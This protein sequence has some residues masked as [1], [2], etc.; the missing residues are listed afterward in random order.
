M[1]D[2]IS[3]LLMF[4]ASVVQ[5]LGVTVF[6]PIV[7]TIVGV[8]MGLA[9][10]K[11]LR[12]GLAF[13]IGLVGIFAV[14]GIFVGALGPIS[15]ALVETIGFKFKSIDMGWIYW[16]GQGYI[17]WG[18]AI[19]FAVGVLFNIFLLFLGYKR[20][21][22]DSIDVYDIT[23]VFGTM[24]VSAYVVWLATGNL[25]LA[26]LTE[27]IAIYVSL[28][29][30][31][32]TAPLT[33]DPESFNFPGITFA[34][35]LSENAPKALFI[36]K[37][38]VSKLPFIGKVKAD[39]ETVKN[40]Y[41][42]IGDPVIIGFVIGLA[43]GLI[44]TATG[45]VTIYQALN[46]AISSAAAMLLMPRMIGVLMEG[47]TPIGDAVRAWTEKHLPGRRLNI[48][49]DWALASGNVTMLAV[50]SILIPIILGL[51]IILPGISAMP[52]SDLALPMIMALIFVGATKGHLLR[53]IVGTTI[54]VIPSLYLMSL[55]APLCT[56]SA[57]SLNMVVPAGFLATS[58]AASF[59]PH[60]VIWSFLF[61]YLF[62][63]ESGR[64]MLTGGMFNPE[65]FLW[66]PIVWIATD[67]ICW[68][69]CRD[70]PYR[71]AN[72][73]REELYEKGM[74]TLEEIEAT[75]K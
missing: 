70:D 14:L 25:L 61:I 33:Q 74:R 69:L 43:L 28:R 18:M 37:Y 35:P 12:A 4:L 48:G 39:P 9:L 24:G 30:A 56:A 75:K 60:D 59:M 19:Q 55:L 46:F 11:S 20:F 8:L 27:C 53:T 21:G 1:P 42:L 68:W 36:D 31:D 72:T 34:H 22:S 63:G 29:S 62:G 50:N 17:W 26:L 10:L 38:I 57:L 16:E 40:R 41:G 52:Y 64:A 73:P 7:F 45:K 51:A 3:D 44:A 67:L 2:V 23:S 6:V 54:L 66:L 13:G 71:I 5:S 49:M 15:N 32:W 58:I 65:I 47:A